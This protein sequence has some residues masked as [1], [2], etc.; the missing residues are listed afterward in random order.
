M[1]GNISSYFQSGQVTV[2]AG[3]QYA[4]SIGDVGRLPFVEMVCCRH[5]D[6]VLGMLRVHTGDRFRLILL[7][8]QLPDASCF[9]RSAADIGE[10]RLTTG[11]LSLAC[12]LAARCA[13]I[14]NGTNFLLPWLPAFARTTTKVDALRKPIFFGDFSLSD[15]KREATDL[16]QEDASGLADKISEDIHLLRTTVSIASTAIEYLVLH[17]M[18]HFDARHDDIK[19]TSKSQ[20]GVTVQR[21]FEHQAD[22]FAVRL[23]LALGIMRPIGNDGPQIPKDIKYRQGNNIL[24]YLGASLSMAF[25][26]LLRSK[27][28]T[29]QKVIELIRSVKGEHPLPTTRLLIADAQIQIEL[30][31]WISRRAIWPG[32]GKLEA[33]ALKG[34]TRITLFLALSTLSA[35]WRLAV[36]TIDPNKP[37]PPNLLYWLEDEAD[38]NDA[39][40]SLRSDAITVAMKLVKEAN[41]SSVASEFSVI[42]RDG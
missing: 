23:M 30:E 34:M 13:I 31:S 20:V 4:L 5:I 26:T 17:E 28:P 39:E 24:A 1:S 35:E 38:L 42:Y 33:I 27:E 22:I 6:S 11:L 37:L 14:I 40:D 32:S 29:G 10:I 41:V 19:R 21:V 7:D 25:I 15:A 18:G 8:N 36:N 9:S 3:T 16:M 12:V 2:G